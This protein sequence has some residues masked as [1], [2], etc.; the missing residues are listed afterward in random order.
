M[1]YLPHIFGLLSL[2]LGSFFL[3]YGIKGGLIDKKILKD[4][5]G[6]YALGMEARIRGIFYVLI[7]VFFWAGTFI[8][9]LS[10]LKK[11]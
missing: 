4:F 11:N 10:I 3:F 2:T 8:I 5:F 1:K 6:N 7:A 9:T